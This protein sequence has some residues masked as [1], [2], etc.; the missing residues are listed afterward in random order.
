MKTRK[1]KKNTLGGI[2]QLEKRYA[3]TGDTVMSMYADYYADS[4][5]SFNEMESLIAETKDQG[6][7]GPYEVY[8]LKNIINNAN[9]PDYV[10]Y[11]ARQA[12]MGSEA[13]TF[14]QG[15]IPLG[16][17]KVG[18][19]SSQID[20][21]LDKWF[22]GKDHPL[23]GKWYATYKEVEGNLFVNGP[24][25][26]DTRQGRLGDCYL[27]A[28]LNGAAENN[29]EAVE[30]MFLE[31]GED[32]WVVRWYAR[33]S[34]REA[35]YVT[36]DNQLPV[37]KT[38]RRVDQSIFAAFGRYTWHRND[39]NNELW[40]ALAEKSYVQVS[41]KNEFRGTRNFNHYGMIR[42][43]TPHAV[44]LEIAKV[45]QVVHINRRVFQRRWSETR[46]IE[47]VNHP[48]KTFNVG[49]N[50][51]AYTIT[52]YNPTTKRFHLHNPWGTKHKDLT[53]AELKSLSRTARQFYFAV[54][55]ISGSEKI[56]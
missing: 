28:G 43:G 34:S 56:S 44:T 15:N 40:G 45:S 21:M 37:I 11:L 8:S 48:G 4:H 24:S 10:R 26:G 2:E 38:G 39:P 12:I 52:H 9:M 32:L 18:S 31:V 22:R 14:F 41:Q 19:S 30:S 47:A 49:L 54:A 29:P 51:H 7:I 13:N 23:T 25:A 33:T 20:M 27:I 16:N 5:I 50:G 36:V 17:L 3:M 42:G 46:F 53:F 55:L 6:Y 35:H 1:N